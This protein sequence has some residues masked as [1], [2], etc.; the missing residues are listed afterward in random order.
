[1]RRSGAIRCR[2]RAR[3]AL[4]LAGAALAGGCSEQAEVGSGTGSTATG[5]VASPDP[6]V[7][8]EAGPAALADETLVGPPYYPEAEAFAPAADA[9][10][11][12]GEL[13]GDVQR[14][15]GVRDPALAVTAAQL[16]V[17]DEV[18]ARIPAL[19]LRAALASLLGTLAEP[20]IGWLVRA[21]PFD[22]I[23]F[24]DPPGDVIARSVSTPD[25]GQ[26][27]VVDRAFRFERPAL[28]SVLLAHEAFHADGEAGDLEELVATAFQALVQLEQLVADPTLAGER[29]A[30]GQATNAWAVIRLNSRAVGSAEL[31]LVLDEPGRT[32]LPGGLE[33]PYFASFFDPSARSTPGNRYLRALVAAVAEPEA[34]PPATDD[35]DLEIVSFLDAN[36]SALS[37]D[38]LLTAARA[39]GLRI[40]A[41][42]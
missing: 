28:L 16:L 35:F 30:L 23:V 24:G 10:R 17:D 15:V 37:V 27:I 12:A 31:R 13:L 11:S 7:L 40:E 9:R 1:M 18:R 41:V 22:R 8:L 19:E 25:G 26:R 2:A 42:A 21:G 20:A 34:E 4:L 39:L 38:E 14:L 6:A 32:V 36:Q 5:A 29:T 3:A 33:R